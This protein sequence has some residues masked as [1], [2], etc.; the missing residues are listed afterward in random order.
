MVD[1]HRQRL[2]GSI[3]ANSYD[4]HLNLNGR[5]TVPEFCFSDSNLACRR[6]CIGQGGN[7]DIST[8]LDLK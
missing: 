2:L 8:S 7:G 3:V 6:G 1:H 5:E 4:P